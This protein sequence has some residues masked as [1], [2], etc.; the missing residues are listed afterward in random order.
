M[1][2]SESPRHPWDMLTRRRGLA[3]LVVVGVLAVLMVLAAAFVTLARLER[4]ASQQRLHATK[5]LLLARSGIEDALARLASGQDPEADVSRYRGED[6]NPDGILNAGPETD[7]QV[8]Q[9]GRLDTD[10]CPLRQAMRPSFFRSLGINPRLLAVEDRQRGY[11]G[12]LSG[13]L[14]PEGNTY[15]LKIQSGGIYVNDANP[16]LRRILG[17]LAEAVDREDGAAGN[18]PVSQVDGWALVDRR[19]SGGWK[20]WEEIRAVLG[21]NKLEALRPYLTLQAWVDGHVISP[22]ASASMNSANIAGALYYHCWSDI[23]LGAKEGTAPT[24]GAPSLAARAPVSLAWARARRP[25][26]TALLADLEGL[27]LE[28]RQATPEMTTATS[29]VAEGTLSDYVGG[30]TLATL[31]NSWTGGNC[32]V[33]VQKILSCSSDLTTWNDWDALCETVPFTGNARVVNACRSILKANFNP[34]SDL[35]KFNPNAF[36]TRQVDK[37][38][39]LA[40]STEF[41]LFPTTAI[42]VE[43]LGRCLDAQGR[44]LAMRHLS[45]TLA[46]PRVVRLSTQAEFTCGNLGDL[47]RAGDETLPRNPADFLSES[48]DAAGAR[49]WGARS[50]GAYA[51]GVALQTYPDPYVTSGG[52]LQITPAPYDGSLQ[53]ATV[54]TQPGDTYGVGGLSMSMLAGFDDGLDLE[55][56]S[57]GNPGVLPD[58]LQAPVTHPLLHD[59]LPNTLHP[60]GCYSEWQRTPSYLEQGNI[61]GLRGLLS[62]WVKPSYGSSSTRKRPFVHRGNYISDT[63][64]GINQFFGVAHGLSGVAGQF[65]VNHDPNDYGREH[66]FTASHLVQRRWHLV[67]FYWDLQSPTRDGNGELV[68]NDGTGTS[69]LASLDDYPDATPNVT[70]TSNLA[71]D[72][73]FGPHTLRLGARHPGAMTNAIETRALGRGADATLDEFAVYTVPQDDTLAHPFALNRFRDGRYYKGG[74]YRTYTAPPVPGVGG[75]YLSPVLPL[76]AGSLIRRV[77]WTFRNP[78]ELPDDYAVV[79]MVSPDLTSPAYLWDPAGSSSK[80]TPADAR[81][82]WSLGRR[83][84]GPFRARVVFLRGTG[85]FDANTPLLNS[86]VFD[87]LS[88]LYAAPGDPL[89]SAWMNP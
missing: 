44:L 14:A 28:E 89:F 85:A 18:G 33:A 40:Y 73:L 76:P 3:L 6:W 25:V 56:G 5:A 82:D 41:S 26:L 71:S 1:D 53:I 23:A 63:N 20:D 38:D 21:Q 10:A 46:P 29:T 68:L 47:Q 50:S 81:Q 86:P 45:A 7:G 58:T 69:E 15:T 42:E 51:F 67:T 88:I 70:D 9:P 11:T 57:L 27:Y 36:M 13:D 16:S 30:M 74:L 66:R 17:T 84:P 64:V 37:M 19:P 59:S 2:R 12:L 77:A 78:A 35:N 61:D 54:E 65:E 87:D 39:L 52:S 31:T 49:T 55:T 8:Y 79:E 43:S 62:F 24:R 22:N 4:R 80:G 72:D 60:D 34:N 48:L 75:S 83:I 32:Q